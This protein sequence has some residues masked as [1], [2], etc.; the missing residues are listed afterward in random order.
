MKDTFKTFLI[1][2]A[3]WLFHCLNNF[4][5]LSHSQYVVAPDGVGYLNAIC[6][7][8]EVLRETK[9]ALKSMYYTY[10]QI[11]TLNYSRPPLFFLTAV[12]FYNI[13]FDKNLIAM[14]NMLY[15]AILLFATYGIGKQLYNPFVGLL[16]AF[17]VSMFPAIFAMSRVIMIDFALTAMV[18]LGCFVFTLNRFNRLKFSL[19]SGLVMGLGLLTKQAYAV[20]LVPLLA[21]FFSFKQNRTGIRLRNFI[22]SIIVAIVLVFHC[23]FL[24]SYDYSLLIFLCHF[25][26]A[27][28]FYVTNMFHFQLLPFFFILFVV[29]LIVAFWSKKIFLPTM[30]VALCII[31]SLSPN[32]SGRLI[33]PILPYIAVMIAGFI[34]SFKRKRSLIVASIIVISVFQY[35]AISYQTKNN[36]LIRLARNLL[37]KDFRSFSSHSYDE[38]LFGLVNDGDWQVPAGQVLAIINATAVNKD[39]DL[40][41]TLIFNENDGRTVAS[42]EYKV[43]GQKSIRM[44]KSNLDDIYLNTPDLFRRNPLKDIM[45]SKFVIIG[46]QAPQYKYA[47]LLLKAFSGIRDQ[48]ELIK[49]IFWP[50]GTVCYLYKRREGA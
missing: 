28:F 47:Q 5:I 20:F 34:L 18:A 45:E 3:L 50:D 35:I 10:N 29:S 26:T 32:R 11:A 16:S 23:Y 22:L 49:T 30:V 31:F 1:L 15:F 24:S 12:P 46:R 33:L 48:F 17:L 37:E 14:S 9:L 8:A 43:I 44:R 13:A 36:F 21:Y 6:S 25:N 39:S 2:L 27:L 7:V 42:L 41:V 40:I 38:G 19:L 4:Y